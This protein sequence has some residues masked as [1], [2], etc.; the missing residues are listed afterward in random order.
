MKQQIWDAVVIGSGPA[1]LS[2]AQAL[3]RSMRRV[4]V[5]DSGLPRNRFAA[6]MHNVLGF[7]GVPP[8]EIIGRGRA[9]AE[10]YGVEFREGYVTQVTEISAGLRIGTTDG[11]LDTRS[12]VVATGITDDLA[13]IP[14]LAEHWGSSVLHCPYCHGWEVRGSRI[15]V[16]PTS[17]MALHQIKLVRQLSEH[18]IAFTDALGPLDED[19]VHPLRARG[20]ALV[21]DPVAEIIGSAGQVTAVRTASG[22]E[23]PVDAIFTAGTMVPHD[24]FLDALRLD[25]TDGPMGSFLTV[26]MT[27]RTSHPRIWAAGN[28]VNPAASVPISMGAGNMAG[29]A[30]NGALVQEDFDIAAR[31]EPRQ[32]E[33]AAQ[34]WE[35]RYGDSGAVW[36]GH[37]NRA[38]ADVVAEL[39]PGRSL[40]L[41]CGEG[42]DVLWLAER[43]WRATGFDLSATAIDRARS[44]AVARGIAGD[45][46]GAGARFEVRD[47]GQWAREIEG[48][49]DPEQGARFDL[50]TASFFQS[51]VELPRAEILRAAASRVA[52]G[53]RL[54]LVAH[55]AA[56]SWAHEGHRA[57]AEFPTPAGELEDLALDP[58]AWR[59]IVAE[60]RSREITGPDGEPATLDDSVVVVQR[61][62]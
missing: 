11:E 61:L 27:G 13:P 40:D 44:A 30:A 49:A 59:T 9:E 45:E 26:D 14:G 28:V 3:G 22:E 55:A 25:R 53:G 46:T 51:P 35:R 32:D 60:V 1:G 16:I 39:P 33:T 8:G 21:A 31:H 54:V 20:I 23:I 34:F 36:S 4:L 29:A 41:G 38:L 56:P 10:S 7:D 24:G 62:A 5:L 37:V 18:V 43:G 47:L 57:H 52:P 6:H 15:A 17:P 48:G 50:V 58:A 12:L 19:T 2:A 42:G